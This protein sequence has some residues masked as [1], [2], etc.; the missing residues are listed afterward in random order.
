MT[1][2][3]S[4]E[5]YTNLVFPLKKSTTNWNELRYK[6]QTSTIIGV[7]PMSLR[8]YEWRVYGRGQ[9]IFKLSVHRSPSCILWN[10]SGSPKKQFPTYEI[11]ADEKSMFARWRDWLFISSYER[12]CVGFWRFL[13][14]F[15]SSQWR[16]HQITCYNPIQGPVGWIWTGL[17][18]T[19]SL[20]HTEKL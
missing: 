7:S 1:I 4:K 17:D 2:V 10:C 9:I 8:R 12:I 3:T 6:F 5:T 14:G 20:P 13:E 15:L 18:Y 19:S 11:L 16:N